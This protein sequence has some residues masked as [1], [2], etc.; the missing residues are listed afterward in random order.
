MRDSPRATHVHNFWKWDFWAH[1]WKTNSPFVSGVLFWASSQKSWA[2]QGEDGSG[3]VK[4]GQW[5]RDLPQAH[6]I[7]SLWCPV[8]RDVH[9][10][11]WERL[12]CNITWPF[13]W[14]ATSFPH[15]LITGEKVKTEPGKKE[16]KKLRNR[17][18]TPTSCWDCLRPQKRG[19]DHCQ[20]H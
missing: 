18:Y 5:P 7:L 20:G 15:D 14:G 17:W 12:Q 8:T 9:S 11:A 4:Q 6:I 1:I 16:A 3:G 10:L 19:Q 2:R 13:S